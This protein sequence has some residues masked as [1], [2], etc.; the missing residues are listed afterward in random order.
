MIKILKRIEQFEIKVDEKIGEKYK[1]I[2]VYLTLIICCLF[3]KY[4][5][6]I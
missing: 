5:V 4:V 6:L 2:I 3:V 1:Y